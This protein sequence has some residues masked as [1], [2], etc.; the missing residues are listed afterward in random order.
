MAGHPRSARAATTLLVAGLLAAVAPAAAPDPM[1][2]NSAEGHLAPALQLR[3]GVASSSNGPTGAAPA[4]TGSSC[5]DVQKRATVDGRPHLRSI[6]AIESITIVPS[7]G[8]LRVSYR[9]RRRVALAPEGVLF[10]WQVFV[11]RHRADATKAAAGFDLTLEDRGA[12]WEP[13]GWTI[14]IDAT[15]DSRQVDTDVRTD[16]ARDELT[17]V[18]PAGFGDLRPPFYWYADQFVIRAYLPR[19]AAP[20]RDY[21]IH[22][23]ESIDCPAA[24]AANGGMPVPRLLLAVDSAAG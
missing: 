12:G 20:R 2:T 22:G 21:S 16:A 3:G 15:S 23:T 11:Y 10:A 19:A 7:A 14:E 6:P 1:R 18:Y 9:F 17:V 8:A 13:A 24:M 5:T 4:G